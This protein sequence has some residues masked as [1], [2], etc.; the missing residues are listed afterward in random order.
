M[1]FSV[2]TNFP[3]VQRQMNQLRVDI[4]GPATARAINRTIEP[5]RPQMARE[6][7]KTFNL[8]ASKAKESLKINRARFVRGQLE[9]KASLESASRRGRSLNLINFIEKTVTFAAAKKRMAGGEG[10][11]Y[12]LRNGATVTKSLELRFKIKR[13][14]PYKVIKGAFIGN[15]G[16][17]VFVREGASRLPIKALQ[18]IDVSQMFNARRVNKVVTKAML[19]RFPKNWA[20]EVKFYTD[21]FNSRGAR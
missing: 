2:K 5:A 17:T 10:G 15:Q 7:S 20:H 19:D 13:G 9:I 12:S 14:G 4:A 11:T 16:R 3:E 1:Q 18:T 6:I 8:T 21:R